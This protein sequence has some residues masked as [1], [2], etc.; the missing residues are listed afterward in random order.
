[1]M[2]AKT[3]SPRPE[4]WQRW[5]RECVLGALLL[6]AAGPRFAWAQDANQDADPR[7]RATLK[8]ALAEYDAGHFEEARA[9]FRRAHEIFPNARTLRS[10]GMAS[11]ELRDYVAAV[12]ALSAA[13]AE[14]RKA[15]SP[16]QR[17]H[18]QGLLDR[19]RMFVDV[20]ALKITPQDARTLVDGRT[21]EFE[22]DGTLLLSFGAHNIEVSKPGFVLRTLVVNVRGNERKELAV[23]LERKA[24]PGPKPPG[25]D[26]VAEGTVSGGKPKRPPGS[27]MLGPGT[28][29]LLAAGGTAL[30]SVGAGA[31]WLFENNEL[32]DCRNPP[33][34]LQ[35]DN[36][37]SIVSRR[38]I[39]VGTAIG[40]G[41]AA[42]GFA[43]VGI[44]TGSSG[45]A[46]AS[47]KSAHGAFPCTLVPTGV[48]C[49]TSF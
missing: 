13:L 42:V 35:C 7:Y 16:E 48:V 29:W 26:S 5:V 40:A 36:R 19:S 32:N 8:D 31:L 37:D 20:Y 43:I 18:A 24:L 39:A 22:A 45:N 25:P 30:L 28:A 33:S 34:G 38:N 46:G 12:R 10:I 47:G 4:R 15:L 41:A 49:R 2:C 14:A 23:T 3:S 21:P 27:S 9:L 17:A 44:V 11:F 6:I 1:M